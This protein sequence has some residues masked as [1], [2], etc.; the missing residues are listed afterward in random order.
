MTHVEVRALSDEEL[1]EKYQPVFTQGDAS[2]ASNLYRS[3]IERREFLARR[4]NGETAGRVKTLTFW[5]V[6]AGALQ[7]VATGW[8]Y[9]VWW[10]RNGF[11]FN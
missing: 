4:A 8:P 7:A 2:N 11:R 3:E 9:L 5:L 10:V 6:A 1:W